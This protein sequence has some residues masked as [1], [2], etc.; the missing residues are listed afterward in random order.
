V[1]TVLHLDISHDNTPTTATT[2]T[3]DKLVLI[4]LGHLWLVAQ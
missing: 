1:D 2:T 3:M 4:L